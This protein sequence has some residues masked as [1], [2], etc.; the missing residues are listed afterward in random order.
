MATYIIFSRHKTPVALN[1]LKEFSLW[2]KK[3][4][5]DNESADSEFVPE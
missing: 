4:R 3:K 2:K 5:N 1:K